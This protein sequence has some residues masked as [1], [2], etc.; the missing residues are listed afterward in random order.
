MTTNAKGC[1][2]ITK[3]D[4]SVTQEPTG[5]QGSKESKEFWRAYGCDAEYN[6]NVKFKE[7]GSGGAYFGVV[8]AKE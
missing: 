5:K 6:F 7:D 2:T 1:P 4:T 8:L 3:I